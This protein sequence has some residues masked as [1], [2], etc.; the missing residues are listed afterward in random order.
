[1]VF[2]ELVDGRRDG[3]EQGPW[4][5]ERGSA[6]RGGASCNLSERTL[7][8]PDG[9]DEASRI[10][11]AHELMHIRVSPH[12]SDH[13]PDEAEIA[14][15]AL[16][17]AEEYRV[18]LLLSK[19]GFEVALLCDG[20]ERQGGQRL[21]ESS[22]WGEALCF[23]LAVLGTGAE[24]N[25]VKGVRLR[26]PSWPVAL[27]AIKKRVQNIVAS[28]DASQV[29]DTNL[30]SDGVPRGFAEVTVPIARLLSRSMGVA[31]PDTPE[32]LR[33][34]RRSLEPGSRR[35][36]SAVFAPLVFDETMTYVTRRCRSL[37][38]RSRPSVTGTVMRHPG[39]LLTDP[40][41]RAFAR[42]TTS[43]GGVIVIDQS[44][45]MDVTTAELE[46]ML[47]TAPDALIVGY[48]HRP[49]DH[50]ETPN[51]WILA[52]HGSVASAPRTG[53]IGNGVDGPVL[54]WALR[55]TR[56]GEPVVWVTDGQVT[57]SHDHPCHKLSLECASL[58]HQHRIR[59]VSSLSDVEQALR[60]RRGVK[61][62]F[63]RVG[64]E[65]E[66]LRSG[67]ANEK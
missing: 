9:I 39:R 17:C 60:G 18:N 52:N 41:Q 20:S 28:M 30:N 51:A 16:D 14:S 27:R 36:P 62:S 49:G 33:I 32:A 46:K 29:G 45:S 6:I 7:R 21:A 67:G 31:V 50:G 22:R 59:L 35:A 44:G 5:I 66:V 42:K 10:V 11:R 26:Q 40:L 63:G 57:D 43:T 61:G 24:S 8:V 3:F 12:R 58:V 64:R 48:S 2:P 4:I 23:Y 1:M 47:G 54:R 19:L 56:R 37:H 65:L 34:F 13:T 38:R 55:S 53:N 25:F 15:R